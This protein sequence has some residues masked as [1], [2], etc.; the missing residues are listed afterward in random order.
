MDKIG[1]DTDG[2]YHVGEGRRVSLSLS[3]CFSLSFNDH[4]PVEPRLA[5]T[6]MSPFWILLEL[7]VM[8]VVVTTEATRRASSSQIV[9]YCQQTNSQLFTGQDSKFWTFTPPNIKCQISSG[10]FAVVSYMHCAECFFLYFIKNSC[11]TCDSVSQVPNVGAFSYDEPGIAD[12]IRS[13]GGKR[14]TFADLSA[15]SSADR[16]TLTS[17]KYRRVCT[18]SRVMLLCLLCC[19]NSL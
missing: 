8:E 9:T 12:C 11:W 2:N 1:C 17:S 10:V 14:F 18:T 7:T 5:G 15:S 6:R 19:A 4:F 16:S 3:L 13:T